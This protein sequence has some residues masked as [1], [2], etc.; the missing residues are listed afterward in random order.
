MITARADFVN[1]CQ[2]QFNE[3]EEPQEI[4]ALQDRAEA[5]KDSEPVSKLNLPPVSF[6]SIRYGPLSLQ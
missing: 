5:E 2:L 3:Q 4:G 6:D 1:V